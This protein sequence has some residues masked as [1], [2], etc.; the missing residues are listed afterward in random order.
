MTESLY[1]FEDCI[2][3]DIETLVERGDVKKA[4]ILAS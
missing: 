4:F 3:A 2:N 1:E